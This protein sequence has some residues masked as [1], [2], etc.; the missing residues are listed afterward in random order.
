MK[1]LGHEETISVSGGWGVAVW[2]CWVKKSEKK[3]G[4]RE[5]ERK[6]GVGVREIGKE[7]EIGRE[8]QGQ[9]VREREGRAQHVYLLS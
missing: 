8:R 5:M 3:E 9:R 6:G 4:C 2:V 7:R 1:F